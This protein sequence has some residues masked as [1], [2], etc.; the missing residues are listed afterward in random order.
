MQ[1]VLDLLIQFY[2][3]MPWCER[4][5]VATGLVYIILSVREKPLC[6][7]FGVVSTGLWMW[8][9]VLSGLY[10]DGILQ[11]YYVIVGIYGWYEWMH[12]SKNKT[13]LPVTRTSPHE[14]AILGAI[15]L[16]AT[17]ALGFFYAGPYTGFCAKH[18]LCP[19]AFPWWDTVT[20]IMSFIA[21]WMLARKKIENWWLWL[22]ADPIYIGLYW[23][24][25]LRGY[26]G[27]MVIYSIMAA[28]GL[29]NWRKSLLAAE[30]EVSPE[31]V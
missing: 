17:G 4:F 12:G 22:I 19:P 11:G 15:F 30:M 16:V 1:H 24:K 31:T 5:V 26:S 23:A 3:D 21:T 13:A 27:L 9:S 8:S 7:L 10:M 28:L 14:W 29:W 25:D 20:T 2:N 6:W 18:N